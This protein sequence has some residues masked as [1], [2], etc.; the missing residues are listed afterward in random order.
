MRGANRQATTLAGTRKA[1]REASTVA[2]SYLKQQM[3]CGAIYEGTATRSQKAPPPGPAA[4]LRT[5]SQ[6]TR[7]AIAQRGDL[8][9]LHQ[10]LCLRRSKHGLRRLRR[11]RASTHIFRGLLRR[12]GNKHVLRGLLQ[13]RGNNRGR[14]R[15]PEVIR[16]GIQVRSMLYLSLIHI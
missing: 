15:R 5:T 10:R 8:H 12:G 11:L 1:S 13:V 3:H 2:E 16:W 7:V 4:E 14:C 9:G 6:H